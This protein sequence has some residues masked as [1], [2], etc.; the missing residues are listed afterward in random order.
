MW[1]VSPLETTSTGA[2]TCHS[3]Q[4][5]PP[6][7]TQHSQS[8]G[9]YWRKIQLPLCKCFSSSTLKFFLL[10]SC[11]VKVC[12]N[13][14]VS[15][16]STPAHGSFGSLSQV[17]TCWT[18]S[19]PTDRWEGHLSRSRWFLA[20]MPPRLCVRVMV[21]SPASWAVRSRLSLTPGGLVQV[22]SDLGLTLS[23]ISGYCAE[24]FWLNVSFF[25]I[26]REIVGR[27]E[28]ASSSNS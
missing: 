6:Y 1:G 18:F 24:E 7:T 14:D 11:D 4:V 2:S 10:N 23:F 20:V 19:G 13:I 25:V 26:N 3:S 28:N 5:P 16:V 15:H 8:G 22:G 17:L 27:G 21:W 9:K 12:K